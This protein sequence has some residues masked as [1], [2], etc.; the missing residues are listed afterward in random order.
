MN[1]DVAKY[2]A[3]LCT[4]ILPP[5]DEGGDLNEEIVQELF[6]EEIR[7]RVLEGLTKANEAKRKAS[8]VSSAAA[9]LVKKK[10]VRRSVHPRVVRRRGDMKPEDFAW[11]RL[12]H[13]PDVAD[14]KTST[15]KLFRRRFRVSFGLFEQIVKVMK[16]LMGIR[17]RNNGGVES[18]PFEIK[19]LSSLRRVGRGSC[20]D[21]I[22]E[23]CQDIP[24]MRT[25]REFSRKFC[26]AFRARRSKADRVVWSSS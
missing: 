19:V 20:W 12:I 13:H 16:P 9:T 24:C 7:K 25:L 26:R 18:I 8:A 5:S 10:K 17:D 14:K 15:G 3:E 4:A 22:K 21:T 23:L 11:W 2:V 6:R 1:Q